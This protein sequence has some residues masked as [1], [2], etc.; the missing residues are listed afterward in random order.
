MSEKSYNEIQLEQYL[1]EIADKIQDYAQDYKKER[2]WIRT[3]IPMY[4]NPSP[5]AETVELRVLEG[6]PPRGYILIIYGCGEHDTIIHAWSF[7][8]G[9][10]PVENLYSHLERHQSRP[11][12]R[13]PHY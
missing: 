12:A 9:K 5:H 2:R 7:S 6:T 13:K 3:I 4:D 11:L 1:K 10:I 8:K